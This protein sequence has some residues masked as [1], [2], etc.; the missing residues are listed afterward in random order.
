MSL[1][2]IT[3]RAANLDDLPGLASWIVELSQTPRQHCLHSWSS[4]DPDALAQQL[5]KYLSESELL[6][7]VA[8]R[9]AEVVGAMGCEYDSELGRGWLHGPHVAL[10]EW[11]VLADELFARV[12][13]GLPESIT[14]LDAYLNTENGR[15]RA[16][17]RRQ[18]FEESLGLSHDFRLTRNEEVPPDES[19]CVP[20]EKRHEASFLELFAALFPKAYYSGQRILR[21]IGESHQA[22]VATDGEEVLGFSV[23]AVDEGRTTAEVEF[24]G[25]REDC[26]GRGLG[27]RLLVTAVHWLVD[28]AHVSEVG[29]NVRDELADARRLYESVGFD[30]RFS[31]VGM[32]RELGQQPIHDQQRPEG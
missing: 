15:G 7:V 27:K 25:V 21:M 2:T 26:R 22:F 32:R 3:F 14:T 4:G 16:F 20:V 31:G 19:P 5:S 29:L 24:V 28:V 1:E 13:D 12:L 9:G 11:D 17:Y 30:L 18:G 10:P 6:Y 8:Q 23:V